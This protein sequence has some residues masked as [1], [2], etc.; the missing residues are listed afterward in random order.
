M[1]KMKK[2]KKKILRDTN[3]TV[4]KI[5]IYVG[6]ETQIICRFRFNYALSKLIVDNGLEDLSRG[7]S[8]DSS[9]FTQQGLY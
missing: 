6:N 9:E 3:C 4:D 1:G 7:G 5:V 2:N 8:P